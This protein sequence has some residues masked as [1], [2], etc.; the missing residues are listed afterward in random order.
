MYLKLFLLAYLLK[1]LIGNLLYLRLVGKLMQK[2]E[3]IESLLII[4]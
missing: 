4:S 3:R 1:I 2:L